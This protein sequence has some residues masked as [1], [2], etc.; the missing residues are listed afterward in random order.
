MTKEPLRS[1]KATL[2][3]AL[4]CITRPCA[5]SV[6]RQAPV[7][8]L[9]KPAL[10]ATWQPRPVPSSNCPCSLRSSEAVTLPPRW[11]KNLR[12]LWGRRARLAGLSEKATSEDCGCECDCGCSSGCATPVWPKLPYL[13]ACLPSTLLAS[14]AA[15]ARDIRSIRRA[16]GA[17]TGAVTGADTGAVV[18]AVV[19]AGANTGAAG[20]GTGPAT[21]CGVMSKP[22]RGEKARP[23]TEGSCS[24]PSSHPPSGGSTEK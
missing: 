15:S 4:I 2:C 7:L 9:K 6:P 21:T 22:A 5:T 16:E 19:G 10:L 24:P 12:T 3:F 14:S 11:A 23:V 20:A 1:P 13:R 17:D 18:G 8:V